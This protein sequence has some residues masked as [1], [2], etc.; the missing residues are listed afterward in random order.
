M[1]KAVSAEAGSGTAASG[2]LDQ[3]A[4]GGQA[5]TAGIRSF[6]PGTPDE[7]AWV[8]ANAEIFASHP[9]QGKMT[10]DDLHA[11][12]AEPWF[13]AGDFLVVDGEDGQIEAYAWLKITGEGAQRD[14]EVYVIGV[15]ERSAG[16]GLARRLMAAAERR[17][18]ERGCATTSLYVDESNGRAVNLYRRLGYEVHRTSIQY[19]RGQPR[20]S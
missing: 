10:L 1:G 16:A 12:M 14:G 6:R 9:E 3:R 15:R 20:V 17:F 7:G 18:A 13:D 4:D 2:L 19:R 5:G 8:A 11:R